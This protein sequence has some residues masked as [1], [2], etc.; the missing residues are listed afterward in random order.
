MADFNITQR[1]GEKLD[2]A[3]DWRPFLG[4]ASMISAT[5]TSELVAGPG[6][7]TL[8]DFENDGNRTGITIQGFSAETI[9]NVVITVEPSSNTDLE[10]AKEIEVYISG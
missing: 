1:V 9:F 10:P 8:T 7:Y 4:G 5:F 2:W 3:L 6:G